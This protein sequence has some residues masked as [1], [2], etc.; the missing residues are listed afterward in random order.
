ME[1]FYARLK[2]SVVPAARLPKE[3]TG[4]EL[5]AERLENELSG[6]PGAKHPYGRYPERDTRA[7]RRPELEM[8]RDRPTAHRANKQ[9]LAR[10]C[11]SQSISDDVAR[12]VS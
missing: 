10:G 3:K 12:R 7:M 11:G 4:L 2:R 9:A 6:H 1:A 5:H 8:T